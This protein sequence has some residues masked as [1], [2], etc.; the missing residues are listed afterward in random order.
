MRE[1]LAVSAQEYQYGHINTTIPVLWESATEMASQGWQLKGLTDNY[2]RVNAIS[3]D[4]LWNQITPVHLTRLNTDG[5]F[6][7]IISL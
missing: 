6:G 5:F 7:E 4:N 2:L 1:I 3:Q